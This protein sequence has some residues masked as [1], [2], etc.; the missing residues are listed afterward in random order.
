MAFS[1]AVLGI[2]GKT[3]VFLSMN[4]G[5]FNV[6]GAK[7]IC[8]SDSKL[9]Q[10]INTEQLYGTCELAE[11]SY[12]GEITSEPQDVLFTGEVVSFTAGV[13][14]DSSYGGSRISSQWQCSTDNFV[15]DTVN[16]TEGVSIERVDITDY[17]TLTFTPAE[18]DVAKSYRLYVD[19]GGIIKYCKNSDNTCY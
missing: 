14:S 15:N 7:V 9:A 13:L 1:T 4:D 17:V 19:G 2:N 12:F 11:V 5:D 10:N 6:A 16:L 3:A 8:Y 18:S